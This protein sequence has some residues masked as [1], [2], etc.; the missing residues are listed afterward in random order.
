[1]KKNHSDGENIIK[2]DDRIVRFIGIPFFGF[3]IPSATGL[4]NIYVLPVH[5]I[6]FYYI[7][8]VI[9][10]WIIWEGNRYLLFHYHPAILQSNSVMQK[11]LMMVA[12]HVFYTIPVSLILLFGWKWVTG[13]EYASANG[14]LV[15][16]VMISVCVILVPNFYEKALFVKHAEMEKLNTE[17]LERAKI[18]AELEALKNQV[19][20]HFMF[21][22]LNS[23]SYLIGHQ[24]KKAQQYTENLAE[25]Y[26]Y[27]LRSK[28]K[29][30]VLLREEVAFMK[31]YVSLLKLR[32]ENVFRINMQWDI[33]NGH[34][35]L[36]PPVSMMVAI[37]NAVKHNEISKVNKFV[38]DISIHDD[39]LIF[40]NKLQKRKTTRDSTKTGLKNLDE[41]FTKLL[42]RNIMVRKEKDYFTLGLPLLR[43]I[44]HESNH[45]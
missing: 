5:A 35:F 20:P 43:L 41:R 13:V 44:N 14:I 2:L 12:L 3:V 30:L 28:D 39:V 36:I 7:Y 1:M 17:Q 11:Y 25:V 8:F 26:R 15:T 22:A 24:P 31:M 32:Y 40:R 19:D 37:E 45:S 38:L 21:N 29:D 18:Q 16:V 6:I 9:T 23:L 10:A 42:G 34:M 4:I 33:R 27:I